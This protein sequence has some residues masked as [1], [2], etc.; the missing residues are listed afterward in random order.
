MHLH[1]NKLSKYKNFLEAQNIP[2]SSIELFQQSITHKSYLVCGT[3][4]NVHLHNDTLEFLGDSILGFI[5]S[6][7][8]FETYPHHDQG[9]LSKLKSYIVSKPFL[10]MVAEKI[11]LIEVMKVRGIELEEGQFSAILADAVEAVIGAIYVESGIENAKKFVLARF[12][13]LIDIVLQEE[14]EKDFKSMLQ[15]YSQKYFNTKPV[16][17]L[18]STSGPDHNKRFSIS[19][20][21][22]SRSV[23]PCEA[24][25]KKQAE[26]QVAKLACE[27]IFP[28][29][30]HEVFF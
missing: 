23:G 15:H 21:V 5:I 29:E 6:V 25:S 2:I 20:K 27:K 8:L 19:V 10:F 4:K 3:H 1:P 13:P 24:H 22:G 9:Y 11:N 18:E 7:Y 26:Q 12:I 14:H 16:Y 30:N 28:D 17:Q